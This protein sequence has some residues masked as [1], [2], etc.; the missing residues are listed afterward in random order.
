MLQK[1]NPYHHEISGKE[2]ERRLKM[3]GGHCYLTRYSKNKKSYILSVYKEQRSLEPI[4]EHYKITVKGSGRLYIEG[5]DKEFDKIHKLLSHYEKH[6]ITCAI[7]SIGHAY[8]EKQYTS[9]D[10]GCIIL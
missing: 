10:K 4:I 8:T 2:A 5:T 7:S 1:H 9:Q 3:R 6:P